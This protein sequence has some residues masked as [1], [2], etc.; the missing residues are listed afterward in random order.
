MAAAWL[1]PLLLCAVVPQGIAGAYY[2]KLIGPIKTNAHGFTGNVYAA[3]DNS[4]II[5]D[6][7]YDGEGPEAFFW[8]GTGK[9]PDDKGQQVPDEN[10]SVAVL[11]AY[12]NARVLLTLPKKIT[13]YQ[14]LGIYCRKFGAN[15]GH[16]SI[17][18]GFELPREQS[19]GQLTTKAH[20][21]HAAEV[22]L[23]DSATVELKQF[24]YDGQ[25]PAAFFVVAPSV[26]ARQADMVKLLDETGKDSKLGAYGGKDIVL[27]LPDGHHWNEFRWFSVYC[28][29]ASA[30]F[31]D[32]AIDVAEKLPVHNPS[33]VAAASA[34][35]SP[36]ATLALLVLAC[37]VAV[38]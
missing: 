6:L 9:E 7:N 25:G 34:G 5:T 18:S 10:G 35:V 23:K 21:A 19:L 13:D 33:S 37:L 1:L 32:V 24:K 4:V 17:P 26:N 20:E 30:S 31:A 11:K 38:S 27:K 8:A 3:N 16:V 12:K 29:Q 14:Y 36:A 22:V 28:F 2:G 15:F